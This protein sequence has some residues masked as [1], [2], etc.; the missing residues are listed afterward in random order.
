[1]T[2]APVPRPS[3]TKRTDKKS[4]FGNY[5]SFSLP[6]GFPNDVIVLREDAGHRRIKRYD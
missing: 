1:M 6:A 2:V 4:H 5:V 3:A